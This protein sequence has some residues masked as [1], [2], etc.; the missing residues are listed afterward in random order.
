MT[1]RIPRGY[2][3]PIV[4]REDP[5][6]EQ[7]FYYQRRTGYIHSITT[8]ALCGNCHQNLP[9]IEQAN[10]H[11]IFKHT[12]TVRGTPTGI[13]CERCRAHLT[14]ARFGF[15]CIECTEKYSLFLSNHELVDFRDNDDDSITINVYTYI[16]SIE[17]K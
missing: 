12:L 2:E 5:S 14:V 11:K 3:T 6:T 15:M 16:Q 13:S 10:W 9:P 4:V 8:A 7:I 17:T 1:P